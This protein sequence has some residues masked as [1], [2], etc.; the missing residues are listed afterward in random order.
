[1][2]KI[3]IIEDD[4]AVAELVANA[5][6]QEKHVIDKVHNGKDG[7]EYLATDDYDLLILDWQLPDTTGPAICTQYRQSGGKS[8]V[9]FLT[10]MGTV[11]DKVTGLD[12]G[13]DDYLVKPFDTLELK[14]RVRALLRRQ[15]IQ[16]T[17]TFRVRDIELDPDKRT[18]SQGGNDVSLFPKEFNILEL[19]MKNPGR[20]FSAED[21]FNKIW[22]TDADVSIDTVRT[23]FL[24]LRQK[25]DMGSPPLIRT[26]RNV[27]YR[28]EP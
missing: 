25:I 15:P 1:M 26:I 4:I 27:G 5:L 10:S 7:Q 2:A 28:L 6:S 11:A 22:S 18:V 8:P 24:R 12:S 17:K 14:G 19:M 9:L 3:L 16:Q 23:T 20:V 21:L 13:A